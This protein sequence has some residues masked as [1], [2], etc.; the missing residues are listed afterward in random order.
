MT[1]AADFCDL[2]CLDLPHAE[3]IRAELPGALAAERSASAAKGLADPTR[4]TIAAALYAGDE[5]CVCDLAWV[6]GLAQNLASHHLRQLRVAGMVSS[7]RDGRLVM[8]SLTDRGRRL[9]TA[10]TADDESTVEG[11]RRG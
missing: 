1:D 10:I 9:I 6:V 11:A 4:F 2:L 3:Q 5:L 8:Y 7:R